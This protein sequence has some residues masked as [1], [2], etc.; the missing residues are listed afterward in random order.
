MEE[1]ARANNRC[2][3]ADRGND[4]FIRLQ[5]RMVERVGFIQFIRCQE[6][7]V[8]PFAAQAAKRRFRRGDLAR[9]LQGHG[10]PVAPLF[11]CPKLSGHVVD[12]AEQARPV[13]L[14]QA[15]AGAPAQYLEVLRI[16]GQSGKQLVSARQV[17]ACRP[18]RNVTRCCHS[19]LG[20]EFVPGRNPE[21]GFERRFRIP[22]CQSLGREGKLLERDGRVAVSRVIGQKIGRV[23]LRPLPGACLVGMRLVDVF[24]K[25][26]SER[27]FF[28]L[29]RE[30]ISLSMLGRTDPVFLFQKVE[31]GVAF[32]DLAFANEPKFSCEIGHTLVTAGREF[33]L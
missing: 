26:A 4:C 20:L 16:V 6:T 28:G 17:V 32:I 1:F 10:A 8:T 11:G 13:G 14:A 24:R 25:P 15:A 30:L 9:A 31:N 23:A 29:D 21:P 19:R 18:E 2:T 33:R 7:V 5:I 22:V 12:I 3:R 27:E